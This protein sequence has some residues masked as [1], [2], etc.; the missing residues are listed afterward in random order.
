MPVCASKAS[1]SAVTHPRTDKISIAKTKLGNVE[2]EERKKAESGYISAMDKILVRHCIAAY[3][4]KGFRPVKP[5]NQK[6]VKPLKPAAVA[7]YEQRVHALLGS[8][9]GFADLELRH[10]NEKHCRE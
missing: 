4:E 6:D 5:R 7:Y 1:C 8:W 3:R 2:K 9:P 10:L